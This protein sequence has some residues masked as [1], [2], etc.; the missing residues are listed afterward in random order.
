MGSNIIVD[1]LR[2]TYLWA[3]VGVEWDFWC[4]WLIIVFLS[5]E[6]RSALDIF[7]SNSSFSRCSSLYLRNYSKKLCGCLISGSLGVER[8]SL[9]VTETSKF[10]RVVAFWM[11]LFVPLWICLRFYFS[12]VFAN[13]VWYFSLLIFSFKRSQ[14]LTYFWW[15]FISYLNLSLLLIFFNAILLLLAFLWSFF[16]FV[17]WLLWKLLSFNTKGD[18][19]F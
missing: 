10:S 8:Y 7:F 11:V 4:F 13:D 3:E 16:D 6:M 18:K 2:I 12:Q 19:S 14:D 15:L 17:A 1:D 9:T 5:K